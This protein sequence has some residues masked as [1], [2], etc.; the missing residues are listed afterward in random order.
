MKIGIVGPMSLRLLNFD[1][2]NE[3]VPGGYSFPMISMLINA[4]V[5]RGHQVVAYTYSEGLS[6]PK[7]FVNENLTICVGRR[8]PHPGRNMYKFE[9]QDLVDLIRKHPVDII[10]AQ[11][12]YE[13]AWA[14]I[15]SGLPAVVTL[16]DHAKII[17]KFNPTPYLFI[18]YLMFSKVLRKAKHLIANS[19]YTFNLLSRAYK[20]KAVVIPNYYDSQLEKLFEQNAEKSNYIISVANGFDRRKNIS[21]S[22]LAFSKL[23][24]Q[25]PGLKYYIVGAGMHKGGQAYLYA[26]KKGVLD[27]VE[28]LG[29]Q[30]FK[31]VL[32]LVKKAKIFLHPSREESF[33]NAAME[34]MIVGTPVVAGKNSGNIP[35]LLDQG[36]AGLLCDINDPENIKEAMQKILV[37]K[38]KTSL[39][40]EGAHLYVKTNFSEKLVVSKLINHYQ[41]ILGN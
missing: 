36:K 10:N 26:Q 29:P 24:D 31:E 1:W 19:P 9:R 3:E 8:F 13:F 21:T 37:E 39:M 38:E 32:E 22:L 6:E 25:F 33:G 41:N 20:K 17:L 14:A 4:L 12:A 16:H 35:F 18:R 40:I 11:W 7:V 34:A 5:A 15:D 30:K 28:F 2:G 27:S 23:K